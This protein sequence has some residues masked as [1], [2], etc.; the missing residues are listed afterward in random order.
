MSLIVYIFSVFFPCRRSSSALRVRSAGHALN[1]NKGCTKRQSL[2]NCQQNGRPGREYRPGKQDARCYFVRNGAATKVRRAD[3]FLRKDRPTEPAAERH[4]KQFPQTRRPGFRGYKSRD[5]DRTAAERGAARR[6]GTG[7]ATGDEQRAAGYGQRAARDGQW[8]ARDRQWATDNKRQAL[9]DGRRNERRTTSGGRWTMNGK[10][11]NDRKKPDGIQTK[12]DGPTKLAR[13]GLR[14]TRAEGD[15][16]RQEK[17]GRREERRGKERCGEDRQDSG[18]R[19]Q[20]KTGLRN[21]R[22]DDTARRAGIQYL[23]LL[24]QNTHRN[25]ENRRIVQRNHASVR[26]RLEV[27][28]HAFFRLVFPSEIV[29][30]SVYI[31]S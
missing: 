1:L 27:D 20:K 9:D 3:A 26:P 7:D 18:V 31:D 21:R 22:P 25:V 10:T 8:A 24:A 17:D 29:A 2:P 15:T 5:P 4:G 28:T 14:E 23:F 11:R 13:C 30:D 19:R 12:E 6:R 16:G